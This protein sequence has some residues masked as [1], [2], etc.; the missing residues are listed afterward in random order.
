MVT[1]NSEI[2]NK[3]V[4]EFNKTTYYRKKHFETQYTSQAS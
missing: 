4:Y 3:P 2:L 1:F